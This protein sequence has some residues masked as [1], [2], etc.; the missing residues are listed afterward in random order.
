MN[1]LPIVKCCPFCGHQ[2]GFSFDNG[3]SNNPMKQVD[4]VR[5]TLACQRTVNCKVGPS[6]MKDVS[7]SAPFH[8]PTWEERDF[9]TRLTNVISELAAEWN[10][11]PLEP[12]PKPDPSQV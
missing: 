8:T 9:Y 6:I 10:Y 5:I 1:S 11:R 12:K 4:T 7:I 2:A 3:F